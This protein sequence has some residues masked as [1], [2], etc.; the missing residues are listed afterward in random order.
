[1][2]IVIEKGMDEGIEKGTEE[3]IAGEIQIQISPEICNRIFQEKNLSTNQGS[4][5]VQFM[6]KVEA[7]NFVLQ[8]LYPI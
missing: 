3:R 7:E 4:I 6:N 5:C 8:S 2:E 1:M